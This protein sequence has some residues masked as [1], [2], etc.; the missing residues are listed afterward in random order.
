MGQFSVRVKVSHPFERVRSGEADLLVDTGATL[1][2]VPREVIEKTGVPLAQRRAFLLAD[3]RKIERDTAGV[4]LQFNGTEAIVTV[5]VAE[6]GDGRLLGATA[7][8]T[9]GYGVDPIKLELIPRALLA[10]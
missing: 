8:G 10:M 9:L 3:G 1:S 7:L 2:W 4:L 5:V 6:P